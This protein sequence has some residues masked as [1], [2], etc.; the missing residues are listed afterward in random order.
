LQIG[1]IPLSKGAIG[2]TFC[3][4]KKQAGSLTG[5][6]DRDI[7]ADI[8]AILEWGADTVISLLEAHEYRELQVYDLRQKLWREFNWLSMPIQD[9]GIPTQAF[10]RGWNKE[11]PYLKMHL[12]RGEKVL[13]HC[14]GGFGRTGVVACMLLMAYG[15]SVENAVAMCREVS[16]GA[17]ENDVQLK[18]LQ[19]Y[20]V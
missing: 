14:K 5:G 16:E 7:D 12:D 9:K 2:L 18:F 1:T 3:P 8:K 19:E 4:G 20:K 11:L 15:H 10:I 17:V 6:W 13:I